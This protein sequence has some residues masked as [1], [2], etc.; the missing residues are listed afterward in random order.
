MMQSV[1]KD[2]LEAEKKISDLNSKLSV[3]RKNIKFLQDHVK[4]SKGI[5]SGSKDSKD[6]HSDLMTMAFELDQAKSK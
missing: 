6:V 3:E 4:K 1:V 5:V 2:K